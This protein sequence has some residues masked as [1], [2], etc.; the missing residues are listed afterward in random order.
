MTRRGLLRAAAAVPFAGTAVPAQAAQNRL[1]TEIV[2]LRLRHTWTTV[3]SSSDYRDTIYC[4]LTSGGLTGIGEGAPIVR[5]K[6]DAVSARKAIERV[7]GLLTTADPSHFAKIMAE[8]FR[9]VKGENAAKAAMDIAL[10]DWVGQQLNIPLYR[11]FGLDPKDAPTTTFSI[12]IDTPEITRQKTREAA[13]YPILKV[14]VGLNTDEPTIEAIRGITKK[15]LRTDANEGWRS[16]EEAVAKINW[17]EKQGVELIEQP[18]PAGMEEETKWIRSRVH[19]PILAD[20]SC[21]HA[22]D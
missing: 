6:E 10:M 17:M 15:P 18:L 14:K 2:R 21:R 7:R 16:K 1:E 19:M 9:Q 12:G 11:Y 3:M 20:E 4:R 8:V 13:E 22:A 5:Y